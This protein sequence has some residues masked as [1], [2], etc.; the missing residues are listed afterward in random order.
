MS[1]SQLSGLQLPHVLLVVYRNP[2]VPGENWE[3]LTFPVKYVVYV[4]FIVTTV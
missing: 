2:V 4:K 1:L 3:Y